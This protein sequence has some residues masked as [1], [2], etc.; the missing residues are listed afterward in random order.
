MSVI[1]TGSH[2]KLLWPGIKRVWGLEYK[3]HEPI[4]P[5]MFESLTSGQAYEED[6]EVV[7]FGLMSVKGQGGGV[8]YDTSQQ[9]YVSRYTHLTYSLGYIVT[10]EELDDNLYEKASLKRATRLARSVYET[11]EIVH[12]NVFN[13]AFT[14]A[15]AG[16]DG[17]ELCATDHPTVSG[18]QSNELTTAADLSEASIEDL[19][20]QMR[21][22]KD[23]RGI[24]FQNKSRT[25]IVPVQL[26]FEAR[27]I[28]G[29]T[30]QPGTANNDI[31]VLKQGGVIP[32]MVSSPYL[33]DEDAWFIRTDCPEGLTHYTRKAATFD[34]DD[35]FD[36]KNLKA[37][38]VARWSQGWSNWR[39]LY[40]SPGA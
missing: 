19:V 8:T 27:R 28:L 40:G 33:T 29:S 18:N 11:E 35:D 30:L 7:G 13:R 36:T 39:G 12:A 16:G 2:P 6:V 20:T 37:S 38:A 24:M 23:S 21:M 4:W 31:N 25:L 22:A 32:E 9:G 26:D 5:K 1:N 17:K 15:Y 10:M 3:R 34:T 14:S